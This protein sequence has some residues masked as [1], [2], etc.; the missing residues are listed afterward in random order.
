MSSGLAYLFP[1]FPV[2]HQTFVLWEILGLHRNGVYPKIYSLRPGTEKQQPEAQQIRSE[3]TYLPSLGSRRVWAAS[4][5]LLRSSPSRYLGAYWVVIQAWRSGSVAPA[6]PGWERRPLKIHERL[7]GWFNRQ[8]FLYLLKSLVLVPQAIELAERLAAD[9]IRHL[10]VHWAT[11][12][13]T[14]ALVVRYVSGLPFSISAHAY[15]IYMVSRMLPA[16]LDAAEFVVTCAKTNADYLSQLAG[17]RLGQKVL[18]SYHGVDVER[19]SPKAGNAQRS[20][21]VLVVSCG[22]LERYKG[23]HLL[24]EACAQLRQE[25]LPIECHIVGEG[26]RRA[27]LEGQIQRLGVAEHVRLLGAQ[28]HAEVAS[29][30]RQGDVFALASELGGKSGRRDVIANVVV[31]AMAAALP[32]VASRIPGAEELVED[33]VTGFLVPPN[34]VEELVVA[35]RRLA[36]DPS[37]RQRIGQA[38]RRRVLADFD[39]SKNV[40]FLAGLLGATA[41]ER[42]AQQRATAS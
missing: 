17:A 18:V 14:I 33:A 28:P 13:A 24:V 15:D 27:Q 6:I 36:Q 10:H 8:P 31:E 11:Y 23:M 25:G 26:S 2:F 1:A 30:L 38:A 20:D 42:G 21:R 39:A 37:E 35:I 16:K 34:R 3:V 12:P 22:Q 4:W 41:G 9:G 32:V 7:R 40:R 29:L 19:F 5:R